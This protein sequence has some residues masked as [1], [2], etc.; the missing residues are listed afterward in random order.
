MSII[1][2]YVFDNMARIGADVTDN[3]QQNIG[4]TRYA[5][6]ML[7]SYHSGIF[8]GSHVQFAT[9]Q[10][11]IV[12]GDIVHGKGI[13]G[14]V[15][16]V[17][18]SLQL[19]KENERALE[20]LQLFSRPF[21][22]VPFLGR[23]SC[24]PVIESRLQQG[25]IASD[26]KSVSTMSEKSLSNYVIYNGSDNNQSNVEEDALNGWFRGGVNSREMGSSYGK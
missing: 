9:Q 5:N 2:N 22:T 4:N 25:E 14:S 17:E 8:S 15:V 3:T 24:D 23:G 1:S 12:F 26:K 18:S 13:N 21:V 19:K 10:P 6:Y 16:D 20:K 11:N 7:S